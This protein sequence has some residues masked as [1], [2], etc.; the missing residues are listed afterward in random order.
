[1]NIPQE[2][3]KSQ[4]ERLLDNLIIH[5]SL[6][7]LEIMNG[8]HIMNYKGR[9]C[10]LRKKGYTIATEEHCEVNGEKKPYARYHLKGFP[11]C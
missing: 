1:M 8:L 9:I 7:S 5:G 4:W 11:K 3:H 2:E 10:D 6:T